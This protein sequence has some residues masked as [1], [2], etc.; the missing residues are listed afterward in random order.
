MSI[1]NVTGKTG[2]GQALVGGSWQNSNPDVYQAKTVVVEENA[3]I[4][5]SS[6]KYGIG[7][8]REIEFIIQAIQLVRGGSHPRLRDK[9]S[10][11]TLKKIQKMKLL[12]YEDVNKLIKSYVFLRNIEH[13]LMYIDD[14]QNQTLP[15]FF[16]KEKI[17]NG[18]KFS[19]YKMFETELR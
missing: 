3:E 8:I 18:M 17:S 16:N 5:A 19:K 15:L 4:D 13:R 10:I 11:S 12:D 9:N 1:I 14:E 6:I 7:G 2:G